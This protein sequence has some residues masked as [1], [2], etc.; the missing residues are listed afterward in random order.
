MFCKWKIG[1]AYTNLGKR[2]TLRDKR[3]RAR[4]EG[5]GESY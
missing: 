3:D 5:G 2:K 1:G 4:E